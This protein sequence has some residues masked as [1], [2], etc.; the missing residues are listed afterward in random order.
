MSLPA[1]QLRNSGRISGKMEST[2]DALTRVSVHG[3]NAKKRL[4]G[5]TPY[6]A[7]PY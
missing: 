2:P 3:F 5:I 1:G 6:E 7:D 4:D